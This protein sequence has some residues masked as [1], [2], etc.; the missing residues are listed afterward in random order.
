[1]PRD[2]DNTVSALRGHVDAAHAAADKLVREASARADAAYREKLGDVP[3]KGWDVGPDH[4]PPPEGP[5]E[6]Q[7][8]VALLDAI[9]GSIPAE[10]SQ[11]LAEALRELLMAVRALIDWYLD[12]LER[13]PK[14]DPGEDRVQDIP[15]S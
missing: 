1:M 7:V 15:I 12:R 14:A 9:R 5:S 10:L 11:Q 13:S 3:E 2:D 4:Q 6:L 8:V